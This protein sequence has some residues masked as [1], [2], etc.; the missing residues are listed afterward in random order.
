MYL[1]QQK[2]TPFGEAKETLNFETQGLRQ[3]SP[4]LFLLTLTAIGGKDLN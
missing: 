4:W 1:A 2:Q 3:V